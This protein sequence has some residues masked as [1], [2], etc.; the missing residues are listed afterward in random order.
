MVAHFAVSEEV[1]SFPV[2]LN[3]FHFI[4]LPKHLLVCMYETEC[5][6]LYVTVLIKLAFL[7]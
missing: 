7:V 5:I 3:V 6:A 1:P 4:A 2:G